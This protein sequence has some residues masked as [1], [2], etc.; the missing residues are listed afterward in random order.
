MCSFYTWDSLTMRERE[1]VFSFGTRVVFQ[2][3]F[4][5]ES[6]ST[7]RER[8]GEREGEG[9]SSR[10][11]FILVNWEELVRGHVDGPRSK[12]C[13]ALYRDTRGCGPGGTAGGCGTNTSTS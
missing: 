2:V 13:L 12:G 5:L 3:F 7:M 1:R 4:H 11:V 9:V 10:N 8:E 6:T